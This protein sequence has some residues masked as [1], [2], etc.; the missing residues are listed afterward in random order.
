M[1]FAQIDTKNWGYTARD[2]TPEEII[3]RLV[4]ETQKGENDRD[5]LARCRRNRS[6][7]FL[8]ARQSGSAGRGDPG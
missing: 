1:K 5:A 8:P 3:V 2:L 7:A 6:F 4:S